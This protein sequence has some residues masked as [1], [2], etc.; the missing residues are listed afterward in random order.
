MDAG[1][2]PIILGGISTALATTSNISEVTLGSYNATASY[3]VPPDAPVEKCV[4]D[5]I[6][7]ADSPDCKSKETVTTV[8]KFLPSASGTAASAQ[9]LDIPK[10]TVQI[11]KDTAQQ[12]LE[13]QESAVKGTVMRTW[14]VYIIYGAFVSILGAT[15][16]VI[17]RTDML[18]GTSE[19]ETYM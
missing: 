2:A 3:F 9:S 1:N 11:I 4:Y 8:Y 10:Q 18:L 7:L 12:A 13:S 6:I 14:L 15:G 19:E 5:T 17:W 16:Y